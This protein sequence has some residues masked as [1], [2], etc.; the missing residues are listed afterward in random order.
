M[1]E[2]HQDRILR[3]YRNRVIFLAVNTALSLIALSLALDLP[4]L[5][6][7]ARSPLQWLLPSWGWTMIAAT[8]W[9]IAVSLV[10]RILTSPRPSSYPPEQEG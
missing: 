10:W 7:W 6:S 9:V 4:W 3:E 8:H 2:N 1:N 5:P